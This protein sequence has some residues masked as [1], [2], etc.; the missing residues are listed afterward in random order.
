MFF[1]S[2]LDQN[3]NQKGKLFTGAS[4]KTEPKFSAEVSLLGLWASNWRNA[5]SNYDYS[6]FARVLSAQFFGAN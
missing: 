3:S 1:L 5:N 2:G 4:T 6:Y